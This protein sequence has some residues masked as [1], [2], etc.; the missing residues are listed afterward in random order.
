MLLL[1]CI[2]V[3][4][5]S[6]CKKKKNSYVNMYDIND[7]LHCPYYRIVIESYFVGVSTY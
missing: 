3:Y 7:S 6:I 1:W 2:G 4:Y 5:K